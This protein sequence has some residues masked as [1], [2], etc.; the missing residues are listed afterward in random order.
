MGHRLLN[1]KVII[2]TYSAGV[3][4]GTLA[5]KEGKEVTLTDAIRIH[6]WDGACSLSQ[7]AVD[8]V[9][10]QGAKN[11]RFAVPVPS[12]DLEWIEI[13]ETTEKARNCIENVPSWKK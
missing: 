13:L 1:Q 4:Y 12:V 11:C 8:G 6:Y 7:L 10:D 3:H 5:S 2:R 9:T